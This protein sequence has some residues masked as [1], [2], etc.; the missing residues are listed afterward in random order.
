MPY[1]CGLGAPEEPEPCP[2]VAGRVSAESAHLMKEPGEERVG[3]ISLQQ[4]ANQMILGRVRVGEKRG[5]KRG[6]RLGSVCCASLGPSSP[7]PLDALSHL[8]QHRVLSL[9]SK[10]PRPTVAKCPVSPWGPQSAP[11]KW[12]EENGEGG[13]TEDASATHRLKG[14]DPYRIRVVR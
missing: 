10:P 5:K 11:V 8:T 4:G 9:Q 2:K 13:T 7:T 14:E 1:P 6:E 12:T 3:E